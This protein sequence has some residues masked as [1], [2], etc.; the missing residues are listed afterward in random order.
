M[1][2]IDISIICVVYNNEINIINCLNSLLK[3][4]YNKKYFEI[5]CCNANSTDKSI[6]ILNEFKE[7]NTEYNI[8]ILN[9][10]TCNKIKAL[11][12]SINICKGRYITFIDPE[13]IYNV[14]KLNTQYNYIVDN[15]LD[16]LISNYVDFNTYKYNLI[17]DISIDFLQKNNYIIYSSTIMLKNNNVKFNEDWFPFEYNALIYDN[18]INKKNIGYQYD[19]VVK[20][21]KLKYDNSYKIDYNYIKKFNDNYNITMGN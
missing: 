8:T 5:I 18:L 20:I 13:H 9:L 11:N 3:Q 14:D 12:E 1:N 4:T 21:N 7:S 2:N 16:I 10:L 19:I 17:D 15:N 6:D